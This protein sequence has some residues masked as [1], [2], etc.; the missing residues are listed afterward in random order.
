MP[1]IR[2]KC[3]GEIVDSAIAQYFADFRYCIDIFADQLLGLI[4]FQLCKHLYNRIIC[5]GLEGFELM[6]L[7]ME[8]GYRYHQCNLLTN[9]II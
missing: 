4:D 5:A 1:V 8:A 9:V 7:N 6:N 2:L 3:L